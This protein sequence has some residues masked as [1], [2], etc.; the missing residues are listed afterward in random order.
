MFPILLS[1]RSLSLGFDRDYL[2]W[3]FQFC[4]IFQFLMWLGVK[5]TF[6]A[7]T[8]LLPMKR[9]PQQEKFTLVS[10]SIQW[11]NRG[12]RKQEQK[13][14]S[15]SPSPPNKNTREGSLFK[16]V[17]TSFHI[18][19]TVLGVGLTDG[20]IKVGVLRVGADLIPIFKTK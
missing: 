10:S 1:P 7:M 13:F 11:G 19:F 15:T 14:Q 3:K 16:K 2:V 8:P 12:N 6:N 4:R 17:P 5:I 20:C 18:R 9:P